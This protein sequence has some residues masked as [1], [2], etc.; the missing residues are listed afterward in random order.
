MVID[1]GTSAEEVLVLLCPSRVC[2][3][4]KGNDQFNR[5]TET[6]KHLHS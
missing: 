4:T 6:P 2:T 3:A 1:P 5:N